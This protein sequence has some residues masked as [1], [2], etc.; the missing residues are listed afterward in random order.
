MDTKHWPTQPNHTPA[1]IF[2]PGRSTAVP[3]IASGNDDLAAAIRKV[4][5]ESPATSSDSLTEAIRKAQ[6]KK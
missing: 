4:R 3:E 6:A 1:D 5:G 2:A